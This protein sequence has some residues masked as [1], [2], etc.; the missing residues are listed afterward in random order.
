[1]AFFWVVVNLGNNKACVVLDNSST[2]DADGFDVPIPTEIVPLEVFLILSWRLLPLLIAISKALVVAYASHDTTPSVSVNLI[3]GSV[4]INS[5][6]FPGALV[7]IPT[8]WFAVSR[9]IGG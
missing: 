9:Y 4:P 1:M 2:A 7:P 5:S 8:L 3:V 6:I